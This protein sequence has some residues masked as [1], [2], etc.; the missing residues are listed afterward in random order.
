MSIHKALPG[1]C[2]RLIDMTPNMKKRKHEQHTTGHN[3]QGILDYSAPNQIASYLYAHI[4][5]LRARIPQLRKKHYF[6]FNNFSLLKNSY[7]G[8]WGK[9]GNARN[10]SQFRSK[11]ES[12]SYFHCS[13]LRVFPEFWKLPHLHVLW[14]FL[15][16]YYSHSNSRAD[17]GVAGDRPAPFYD[18]I[19]DK[20]LLVFFFR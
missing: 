6:E 15:L 12:N 1:I 10:R 16:K 9:H 13:H 20:N 3:C 17:A 4:G 19:V 2:I 5:L 11:L 8:I 7:S 18:S 14:S